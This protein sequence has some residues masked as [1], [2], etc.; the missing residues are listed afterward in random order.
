MYM[1]AIRRRVSMYS[2]NSVRECS[3]EFAWKVGAVPE[4]SDNCREIIPNNGLFFLIF[5]R[6]SHSILINTHDYT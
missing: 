5:H 2:L 4:K 3:K 1:L 6:K